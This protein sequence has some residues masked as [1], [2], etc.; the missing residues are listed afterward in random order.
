M[1]LL[2][3]LVEDSLDQG[4]ARAA[5]RRAKGEP[6][7]RHGRWVLTAGL[8]AVGLLL[9]TAAAQTSA[10]STATARTR[11]ALAAE[12]EDRTAAN[13]ELEDSLDRQR[14]AVTRARRSSLRI[15]SEGARLDRLLGRLEAATGAVPVRGPGVSLVLEDAGT[16]TGTDGDPR[17][18]ADADGRVTD[19][20]LQTLVNELWAAGAEAVAINE[21]RLTAVSAIRS[22]GEAILVDFRPLRPPYEVRAVG[23]ESMR[24]AFV[25][26]FGGSYLQVLRDYGIRFSVEDR[27]SMRLPASAGL[28]VRYASTRAD[29]PSGAADTT[30][31]PRADEESTP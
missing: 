29:V 11:A 21:Q 24:P 5:A 13:Q 16:D 12:I 31:P 17:S 25:E 7:A 15:T 4:Y 28:T 3:S 30:A 1:V 14:A 23:P 19:R 2:T 22:A 27:D 9:A 20:D 18:D 6:P 26:G 10:R 8:L